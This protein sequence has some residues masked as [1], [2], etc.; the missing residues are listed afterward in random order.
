MSFRNT[1]EVSACEK[2]YGIRSQLIRRIR[3]DNM[4]LLKLHYCLLWVL[5]LKFKYQKWPLHKLASKIQKLI[6][7]RFI[8][9]RPIFLYAY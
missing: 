5:F 6:F 8:P 3:S 4:F 1:S 2:G 9:R 7:P